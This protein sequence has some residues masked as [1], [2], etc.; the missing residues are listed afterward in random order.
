MSKSAS[1]PNVGL[2]SWQE[3]NQ[4][5]PEAALSP[6]AR[7][8]RLVR[9]AGWGATLFTGLLV[10]LLTAWA[11]SRSP[12]VAASDDVGP[13]AMPLSKV[14][15][16][17]DGMM[18][19]GWI[20]NF[21]QLHTGMPLENINLYALRQK[22]LDTKQVSDAVIT[23]ERPGT[24][25]IALKE[26]H[27]ALRVAVDNGA[28]GY[29]IYLVARD[30]TVFTGCDFPVEILNQIPW[31]SGLALHRA[32]DGSGFEPVAGMDLV[33][34]LL[35]TARARAPKIA[36]QWGVVDLSQFDP[37]PNAPVSLIKITKS[38]DLGQLTFDATLQAADFPTQID[39]LA[40]AA[41][42]VQEKAMLISG[43]DMSIENQV[44]VRPLTMA[45]ANT[46]RA[47]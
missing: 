13:L 47:R 36:A 31:M 45:A 21:L 20:A 37:R 28:G 27:P 43:M 18:T 17:T 32:K 23:R 25:N 5:A 30:G 7:R 38:G 41:R 16:T 40:F 22:L 6:V 19:E 10:I 39:R 26:R 8:N 42:T 12:A 11:V 15:F 24:L 4:R 35:Q 2:R 3:I 46:R 1:M 34:T 33:A 29:Q 9:W 14:Q 44:V